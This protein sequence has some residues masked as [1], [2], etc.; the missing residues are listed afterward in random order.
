LTTPKKRGRV[1]SALNPCT[2]PFDRLAATKL[3]TVIG[4]DNPDPFTKVSL[5][6]GYE[7]LYDSYRI[8]LAC[9]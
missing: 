1:S 6:L 5:D 9:D 3:H 7:F 2:V 4:S 8:R